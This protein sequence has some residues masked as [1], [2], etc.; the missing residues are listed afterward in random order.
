MLHSAP[1]AKRKLD[2]EELFSAGSHEVS[3]R[4][5]GRPHP[6][7]VERGVGRPTQGEVGRVGGVV[8]DL[9]QEIGRV[10]VVVVF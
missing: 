4:G 5:V 6:R 2:H 10:V 9:Q 1:Q 8:S 7:E 3:E